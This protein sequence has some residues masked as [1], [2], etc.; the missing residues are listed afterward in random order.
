LR[1]RAHGAVLRG[2]EPRAGGRR[3]RRA[4][5]GHPGAVPAAPIRSGDVVVAGPAVRTPGLAGGT[6]RIRPHHSHALVPD[7][8]VLAGRVRHLQRG[9]HAARTRAQ[10][11]RHPTRRLGRGDRPGRLDRRRHRT[12][13]PVDATGHGL[14]QPRIRMNA[15]TTGTTE[16]NTGRTRAVAAAPA[17]SSEILGW[18]FRRAGGT[19]TRRW[20]QHWATQ[21]ALG[22]GLAALLRLRMGL[23]PPHVWWGLRLGSTAGATV[24]GAVAA[25]TAVPAV[26]Q[27]M[28]ARELP[29]PAWRWG[30]VDIPL[31]TVWA[32]EVA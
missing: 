16:P 25:T 12:D 7:R 8:D 22:A 30:L 29:D 1:Q 4:V 32:E 17:L 31:G 20:M 19:A 5:G 18:R 26:R 27:A 3:H 9:G 6:A 28:A 13:P 2:G 10:L 15:H 24:A 14:R 21:A 11:Q 23:R